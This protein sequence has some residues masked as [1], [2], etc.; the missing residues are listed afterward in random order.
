MRVSNWERWQTYRKDRGTPPW[1]KVHRNLM[2]NPEWASLTD[3]EKGQLV[4]I[5]VIAADRQGHLPDDPKAIAK[6]AM[7]DA[8]PNVNKFIELGFLAS[9]GCHDDANMTPKRRQGDAKV[10]PKRRQGDAKVTPSRRQ[11]D[12]PE[13]ET[14]TETETDKPLGQT[15]F[16]RWWSAY[17]KKVKKRDAEK[18]WGKLKPADQ[19][20]AVADVAV[21]VK[22]DEQWTRDGGQYIPYPATYLR[23][24]QWEDEWSPAATADPVPWDRVLIAMQGRADLP[25]DER[26]RSA[27]RAM[28]GIGRLRMANTNETSA[29][30]AQFTEV[31]RGTRTSKAGNGDLLCEPDHR[32][33]EL[34]AGLSRRFRLPG[35]GEPPADP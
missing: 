22:T 2:T 3:A 17:P 21:R 1:I 5:W 13:T 20:S 29:L 30:K 23:A 27:V 4:S 11:L 14:E 31:Y 18:A 16:D 24:R 33:H 6:I 34:G 7:L 28:G 25:D 32:G 12:A 10:T 26:I 9:D 35:T 8:P 19:E 15:A